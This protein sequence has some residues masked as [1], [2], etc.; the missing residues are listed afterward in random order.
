MMNLASIA[1]L[2][3]NFVFLVDEADES[4]WRNRQ[5]F[6]LQLDYSNNNMWKADKYDVLVESIWA[7]IKE[8]LV[9]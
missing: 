7:R 5:S 3:N 2:G 9:M 8:L 6:L 1:K 4:C